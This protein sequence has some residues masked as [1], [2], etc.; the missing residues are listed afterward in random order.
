MQISI[1]TN[2]LHPKIGPQGAPCLVAEEAVA[3]VKGTRCDRTANHMY[4]WDPDNG[5]RLYVSEW[6]GFRNPTF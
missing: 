5:D 6:F 1:E 4:D 3:A 2:W